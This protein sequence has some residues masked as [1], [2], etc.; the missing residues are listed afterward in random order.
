M[1]FVNAAH[2]RGGGGKDLV[3]ENE[4]SFLWGELD[5]LANDI[6]ELTDSE[7]GR[8]KVL[9]LIDRRDVALLN[10]LAN[11]LFVYVSNKFVFTQPAV[12]DD[13]TRGGHPAIGQRGPAGLEKR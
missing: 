11:N 13:D 7:I 9:L 4:D 2:E 1:F 12:V 5:P 8:Y 10:L 6:D 3:D